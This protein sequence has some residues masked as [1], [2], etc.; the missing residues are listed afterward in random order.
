MDVH[1][2]PAE[3]PELQAFLSAFQVRFRR[4]EGGQALERYM[5]GLLTE[6][7][8]KN[9]DTMAQAI[10]GTSAQRL[11][12]CL[13]NMQWDEEDLNRQRVQ[14]MLAAATLGDGVLVVDDTGVPKQGTASVGVARQY[15]GTLGTV[16]NC[17]VA[18]TCCDT[19]RQATWLVAVRLYLP[20][21][22][23]EDLERRQQARVPAEVTFHTKPERALALLD[24]A[25]TGGVP[26]RCVVADADYGDN[27]N[28]LA[29]LESR[30]ERYVVAVRR[31][32]CVSMGR[33]AC[34]PVWRADELLQTVPRW[35]WRTIRWRQGTKGWLRKKCVAVRCWRVMAD[36]QRHVG[37]LVGER[38]TRGQ[39]EE[40]KYHWSNLS[41]TATLEEL[42]GDAHRRYA[43][44]QFHEEAT[45]ELGW[46][47]YQ[48]RLWPGFH[49]HAVAVMLAYSFLVW[50]ELCQR[51]SQ[52]RRGRPRAPFSPSAGSSQA[53]TASDPS[54]GRPVAAP[55]SS[56]LVGNNGSV[57]GTLLTKDLTE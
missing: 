29:G 54:R 20:E 36:G 26:Y 21:A 42:A 6:L 48:G 7:A 11:Q 35:Q 38:A 28:F 30:Q 57:H 32:F 2:S 56:P 17:Q 45:G 34:S 55:P 19:D 25:R 44:E 27:P 24:Q 8:N 10:P 4:P 37:C 40:R 39:P 1:A 16:G 52:L 22:W 33:A 46:D 15:A 51:R 53:L 31:D 43:V 49:R 5:T 41:A 13:T 47:H 12:E 50:L 9:C 23:A 14:K 18:V 3:L